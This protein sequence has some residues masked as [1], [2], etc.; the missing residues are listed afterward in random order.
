MVIQC[1]SC[2]GLLRIESAVTRDDSAHR[3]RCPHCGRK[4]RIAPLESAYGENLLSQSDMQSDVR[5]A[6][7]RSKCGQDSQFIDVKND[8]EQ[9][10]L[11]EPVIEPDALSNICSPL[12]KKQALSA[13]N[14]LNWILAT[15]AVIAFFAL[16][17]NLM[18]PGPTGH[19]FFGGV[20]IQGNDSSHG[21]AFEHR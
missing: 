6:I 13:V 2:K 20:T 9:P 17:V 3:V 21:K 5:E 19:R 18:L 15:L 8:Y 1:Q 12:P 10:M 16:F 11:H 4:G 14:W 7:V